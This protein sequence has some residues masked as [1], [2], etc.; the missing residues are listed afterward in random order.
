[1]PGSDPAA[2]VDGHQV[3]DDVALARDDDAGAGQGAAAVDDDLAA[4][5]AG[6]RGVA[7]PQF[8]GVDDRLGQ[9]EPGR[10]GDAAVSVRPGQDQGARAGLGDAAAGNVVVGGLHDAAEGQCPAGRDVEPA[11]G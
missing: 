4:A 10:G 9:V 2:A 1:G 7:H 8:A 6:P 5:G 3:A 11:T